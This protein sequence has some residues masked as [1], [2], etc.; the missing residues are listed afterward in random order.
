MRKI[1]GL[2]GRELK[3]VQPSVLKMEYELRTGQ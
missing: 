1:A 2:A 3:W